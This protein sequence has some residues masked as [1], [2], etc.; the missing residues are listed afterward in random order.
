MKGSKAIFLLLPFVILIAVFGNRVGLTLAKT[1]E[2]AVNAYAPDFTLND[3]QGKKVSLRSV[4]SSHKVT[5]INFWASWCPPCRGEIPELNR[6]YADYSAKSLAI[7]GVNIQDDLRTLK[8]FVREK[9]M[10]FP[11]LQDLDGRVSN[12]YQVYYIP[13]TFVVDRSGKIR[14][15]IRGGTTYSALKSIVGNLLREG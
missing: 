8:P 4:A 7:L 6:I 11:V 10:K 1:Y 14:R 15:I 2:P 3:L 5:L 13:E 9:A 12:L